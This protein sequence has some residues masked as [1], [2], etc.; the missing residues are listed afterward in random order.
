[1][2]DTCTT[3]V[4]S[5]LLSSGTHQAPSEVLAWQGRWDFSRLL[6]GVAAPTQRQL[7]VG[8]GRRV[9]GLPRRDGGLE[10]MEVHGAH[11]R[12]GSV[13]AE[14]RRM[15]GG[16]WRVAVAQPRSQQRQPQ[17]PLCAPGLWRQRRSRGARQRPGARWPSF[18][19]LPSQSPRAPRSNSPGGSVQ[20]H[21]RGPPCFG[22]K[23]Q[24]TQV[25]DPDMSAT[26][27]F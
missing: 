1:V 17:G 12:R 13:P 19:S 10:E 18:C 7:L 8:A 9:P 5:I 22:F 15:D 24:S 21:H 4:L 23:V 3:A 16:E 26:L 14:R 20:I 27:L 6:A 25:M 11:R 2:A